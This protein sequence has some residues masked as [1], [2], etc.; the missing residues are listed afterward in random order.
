MKIAE[1]YRFVTG[2]RPERYIRTP[3]AAVWATKTNRMSQNDA[4]LSGPLHP[5]Q[6]NAASRN[7]TRYSHFAL[8]NGSRTLKRDSREARF[9][10]C[11]RSLASRSWYDATASLNFF[12]SFAA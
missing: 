7:P 11:G 3:S 6:A 1:E 10:S 4:R 8:L 12:T 5:S 9:T 2:G